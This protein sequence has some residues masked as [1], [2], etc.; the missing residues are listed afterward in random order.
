MIKIQ[1]ENLKPVG[2]AHAIALMEP[3]AGRRV[4]VGEPLPS[5]ID[6][7]SDTERILDYFYNGG[8]FRGIRAAM[9]RGY[10]RDE[11]DEE[12]TFR[13]MRYTF[14]EA[15]REGHTGTKM[16]ASLSGPNVWFEERGY[17]ARYYSDSHRVTGESAYLDS[18]KVPQEPVYSVSA[19]PSGLSYAEG[20]DALRTPVDVA[21]LTVAKRALQRLVYDIARDVGLALSGA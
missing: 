13:S 19:A 18:R 2:L 17:S 16:S 11:R 6:E 8:A 9:L 10:I 12:G 7:I 3:F 15:V 20:N 14:T 5:L 1:P 4:G 21:E